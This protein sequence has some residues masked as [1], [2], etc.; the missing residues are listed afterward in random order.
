[1]EREKINKIFFLLARHPRLFSERLYFKIKVFLKSVLRKKINGILFEFNFSLDPEIENM[2]EGHYESEIV[3]LMERTL[4]KGDAFI[5]VGANIGYLSAIALGFV[6]KS[7]QVHSFEPVPE[8]FSKLN[9]LVVANRAYKI[10]I[11][12]C[13]LGDKQEKAKI[14][15]TSQ[16][17]I[18]W[19][20]IVPKFMP[21]EN[22]K[23]AI[24]VNVIRLDS[25]IKERGVNN[26]K[27][28]KIDVEGFEFPVLKGVSDYFKMTNN[29]PLII[30]EIAPAA[31][32]LLGF[33]IIDLL[34]Y[35]KKYSYRAFSTVNRDAEIDITKLETTQ[36]VLFINEYDTSWRKNLS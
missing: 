22:V 19:N 6:G 11:N 4:K 12:Q 23:Q 33:K 34:K 3:K 35:M 18:G 8:Y 2:Y 21:N 26:I 36:N 14:N 31:Y 30:C 32:P 5:D 17:N 25:Y 20:T 15:V 28:I 16:L 1:M 27:L 10:F 24:E 7:G 29:R 13:A 9:K